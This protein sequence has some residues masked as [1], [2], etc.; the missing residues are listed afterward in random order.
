MVQHLCVVCEIRLG[1][2]IYLAVHA[3]TNKFHLKCQSLFHLNKITES[4]RKHELCVKCT[5][6]SLP[7]LEPVSN[8]TNTANNSLKYY[9]TLF[10]II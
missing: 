3:Q 9:Q 7:L 2:S 5:L 8:I 6:R 10:W 1:N 4:F